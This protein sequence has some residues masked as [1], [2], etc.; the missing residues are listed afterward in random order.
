MTRKFAGSSKQIEQEGDAAGMAP[1]LPELF[2]AIFASM[3]LSSN[4]AMFLNTASGS[5][6]AS[7]CHTLPENMGNTRRHWPWKT[8]SRCLKECSSSRSRH[9]RRASMSFGGGKYLRWKMSPVAGSMRRSVARRTSVL[10][11]ARSRMT[12][13]TLTSFKSASAWSAV[14]GKPSS[15]QPRS[16]TSA[17]PR[18]SFTRLR[19]ISSGTKQPLSMNSLARRPSSV[20][21]FARSRNTSPVER[22]TKS[23]LTARRLHCVPFPDAGGPITAKIIPLKRG[24]AVVRSG[25]Q[26]PSSTDR[27]ICTSPVNTGVVLAP[28]VIQ[29]QQE[30][31]IKVV[32]AILRWVSGL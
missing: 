18:R 29:G 17:W 10:S 16:F 23:Y 26:N 12:P 5:R 9:T 24:S 6:V 8:S 7:I 22:W 1:P 19:T 14:R 32:P 28:D 27:I 11:G 3:I 25:G 30:L 20:P 13:S 2:F 31:N 15:K 21:R 4:P